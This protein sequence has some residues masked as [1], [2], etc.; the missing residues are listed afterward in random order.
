M[1]GRLLIGPGF[2]FRLVAS[3]LLLRIPTEHRL[4]AKD[5]LSCC[6]KISFRSLN[7]CYE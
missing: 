2:P 7:I 6:Q 5:S 4:N 1:V 3:P